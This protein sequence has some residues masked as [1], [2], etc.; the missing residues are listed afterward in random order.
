MA[1]EQLTGF[2]GKPLK[3]VIINWLYNDDLATLMDASSELRK[4]FKRAFPKPD[5]A[6]GENKASL[7]YVDQEARRLEASKDCP[8][9][10]GKQCCGYPSIC[11]EALKHEPK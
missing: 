10:H 8:T 6:K 9:Q 11:R 5:W 7:S 2:E 3:V 4:R 1:E